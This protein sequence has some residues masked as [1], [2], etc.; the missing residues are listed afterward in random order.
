MPSGKKGKYIKW[1]PISV[2]NA[3]VRT[4]IRRSR[5]LQG[6]QKQII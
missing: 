3:Y 6:S 1:L 5:R 2:K 4:D